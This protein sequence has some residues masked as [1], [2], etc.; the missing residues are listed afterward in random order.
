MLS[1]KAILGYLLF[2]VLAVVLFLYLLFPDQAVKAYMDTRLE[3]IDPALSITAA[4]IRPTLPPALKMTA[5]DLRRGGTRLIHLDDARVAPDLTTLF[6]DQRQLRFD[7]D[8]A[9]GTIVGR[10]MMSGSSQTMQQWEADLD[11][12]RIDQIDAL[13][14]IPRFTLSGVLRGHLMR[15]GGRSSADASSGMLT[16]AG[17][18]VTLKTPV[19]GIGEVVTEQTEADFSVSGQVLRV[20]SLTFN[21]P[22]LEGRLSGTIQLRQPFEQS[23]LNLS[24]NA[25]PQPELFARLQ[26][27]LPEGTANARTLGTRGLNFRIQGSIDNPELSMR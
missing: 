7:A 3:A 14:T 2:A 10:G 16:V 5:V 26:G 19:F 25:K 23:R 18:T 24:G 13:K 20:R 17:L 8:V 21:G 9:D 4:S 6:Q 11:G 27:A 15:D 12:I 22:M 1:F